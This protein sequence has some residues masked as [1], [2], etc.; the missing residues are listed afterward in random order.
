MAGLAETQRFEEGAQNAELAHARI[1]WCAAAR[2]VVRAGVGLCAAAS[3]LVVP[4]WDTVASCVLGVL[5]CAL[6]GVQ[7]AAAGVYLWHAWRIGSGSA[8]ALHLF[9]SQDG[10]EVVSQVTN[11]SFSRAR[12][13][14]ADLV[15]AAPYLQDLSEIWQCTDSTRC[16]CHG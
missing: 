7:A 16:R 9:A 2:T 8:S 13:C 3:W 6:A 11:K 14:L 4:A 5:G 1:G 15:A 12:F 10:T